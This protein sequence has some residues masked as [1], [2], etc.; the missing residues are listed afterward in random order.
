[1]LTGAAY[2]GPVSYLQRQL[3][4]TGDTEVLGGTTANDFFN[5]LGGD[6][7]ANAAGGED[8]L[9]GGTGSSFLTGG[10]GNDVFFLDGRG[11]TVTWSTIT[12][13][14]PG[15]QLSVWGWQPGISRASWL[16]RA[17]AGGF[18]G[19]TMHGDLNGDGTIDTSVT[20]S[21]LSQSV[22]P[23]PL[24]QSGLLWFIG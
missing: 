19:V 15:E 21:G 4:G 17:G 12:D 9:D 10:A 6:D 8:V 22:L 11:G 1:M 2:S 24:Q 20:W 7:A 5:L 18:E 23:T 3:I 13:W 14:A 16:D